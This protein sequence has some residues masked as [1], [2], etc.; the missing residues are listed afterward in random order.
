M[1]KV[2]IIISLGDEIDM[3][4]GLYLQDENQNKRTVKVF[5]KA[6]AA[7][8]KA[9]LDLLVFPEFCYTPFCG[10]VVLCRDIF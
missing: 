6:M 1:R 5:D 10:R 3:K 9:N 8:K 4:I 7:V 2:N